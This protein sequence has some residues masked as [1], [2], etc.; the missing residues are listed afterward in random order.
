MNL[1]SQGES[2]HSQG[3]QNTK[4]RSGEGDG[5]EDET[6][7]EAAKVAGALGRCAHQD[8]HRGEQ[9]AQ[10]VEGQRE[11]GRQDREVHG[12]LGAEGFRHGQH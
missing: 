7:G 12:C 2:A 3:E 1:G 11:Q 10:E 4:H 9:Q 5:S 8:V 6:P